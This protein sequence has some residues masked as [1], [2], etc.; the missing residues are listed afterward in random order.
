MPAEIEFHFDFISPYT[1]LAS[2]ALPRLAAEHGATITYHPFTL[3][4]LMKQVGNRPTTLE[5]QNKAVYAIADLRRW[6]KADDVHFAP[7]P[8][9]QAIDFRE[10]GR[11]ALV[12]A[13]EG[14][15][16]GYVNAVFQ[17]VWSDGLDLSRR[18]ALVGVLDGAGYDGARLLDRAGSADYAAKLEQNTAEAARRGVFGSPTMFAGGE[19]FFGNDRLDF[20]AEALRSAA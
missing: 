1:Y 2:L 7:T 10:L 9:W 5:C 14:R 16:A 18:G 15:V 12:A 6:A 8:F 13:D 20:V 17:A 3:I 4:E 11:G 19:M